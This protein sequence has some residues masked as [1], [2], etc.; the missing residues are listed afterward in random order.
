MWPVRLSK[1]PGTGR[2]SGA[3]F[4]LRLGRET[5][6]RDGSYRSRNRKIGRT[7]RES[8]PFACDYSIDY[9]VYFQN[10]IPLQC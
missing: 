7:M 4:D 10:P 6:I 8:S 9:S 5:G 2:K 3:S 1:T